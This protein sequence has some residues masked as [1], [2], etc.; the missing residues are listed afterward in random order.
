M[1]TNNAALKLIVFN[2]SATITAAELFYFLC[3][4]LHQ[5]IE[6]GRKKKKQNTVISFQESTVLHNFLWWLSFQTEH[7]Q[8]Q[9]D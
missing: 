6:M 7:V 4:F 1:Y 8:I 9:R 3:S 2:A 5:G